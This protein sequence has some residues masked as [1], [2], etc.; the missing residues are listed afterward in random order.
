[1]ALA[2]IAAL[3]WPLLDNVHEMRLTLFIYTAL[4][5]ATVASYPLERRF[6]FHLLG[7]V[8]RTLQVVCELMV[9]SQIVF[10]TGGLRSPSIFLYLMTIISAAVTNR[11]VGTLFIASAATASYAV[12]I[13]VDA[14]HS[15]ALLQPSQ[16]STVLAMLPDEEFFAV[17]VRVCIFYLCAFSGGYLAE[18]LWSHDEAL[19]HTAQ[20]LEVAKL[21][22]GDILTHLQS[23]IITVDLAGHI[24]FFNRAAEDILAIS[25]KRVRGHSVREVFGPQFPELAERLETVLASQ[26]MDVRT[27]LTLHRVDGKTIPIGFS[28]SVLGGR[29]DT[30]RG[31]IGIFQDLTEPKLI[32]EKMRMQDRLAA[33]GELSAAIAHE[34][35]NPLAAISGSVEVLCNELP[36][37]GEN[38]RLLELIIRESGRLNKILTDFLTYAR[39]RP[40]VSGRVTV[41]TV[42]DEVLEITRRRYEGVRDPILRVRQPHRDLAVRSDADHLKQLLINLVFNAVEA[43]EVGRAEV[44]VTVHSA[45]QDDFEEELPAAGP[46]TR[47]VSIS[48]TDNG[49][50]IPDSVRN[51]LFE[52]F[53]S[54]KPN[55]TGLGLAIVQR[56]TENASGHVRV[57]SEPGQGTTFTVILPQV[58]NVEPSQKQKVKLESDVPAVS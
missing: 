16:W 7:M 52:P 2:V 4:T 18:R 53:V 31:V 45:S 32:E 37:E 44:V 17:F 47:W 22:T 26:K 40:T 8:M 38:R 10:F 55:G 34:I 48:V 1:M 39:I 15:A 9:V 57:K 49:D 3:A 43:K 36:V 12:V 14:G 35:R 11:L 51:R 23:G 58:M 28:T 27:E 13:L 54:S 25:S 24:V 20:Q 6:K 21:E 30:P 5:L 50:G 29:N 41:A 42:L 33:I 56:L 19:A 46:L